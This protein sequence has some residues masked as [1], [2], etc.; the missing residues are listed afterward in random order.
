S[1]FL[2]N[3]FKDSDKVVRK[4]LDIPLKNEQWISEKSMII[5]LQNKF[6]P[7]EVIYQASPK[8]LSPLR[9]DAFIPEL[10]LALEYQGQQHFIPVEIFGGEEGLQQTKERDKRKLILSEINGVSL[11]YIHYNE[12]ILERIEEIFIRY[13]K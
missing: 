5:L 6:R 11:E 9:Y 12:N 1:N 13:Y 3:L 7:F 4:H 10:N 2:K 8:W